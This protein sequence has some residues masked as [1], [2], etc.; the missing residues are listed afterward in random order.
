MG[1]FPLYVGPPK[2][3]AP[4][5]IMRPTAQELAPTGASSQ[6]EIVTIP[7]ARKGEIPVPCSSRP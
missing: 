7:E 4:E 2:K 1:S 6:R 5:A 3:C